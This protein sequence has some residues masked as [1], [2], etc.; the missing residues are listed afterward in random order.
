MYMDK[1]II[2]FLKKVCERFR[3]RAI[4]IPDV[5]NK[6]DLWSIT[7][8]Q[9]YGIMTFTTEIF[10]HM[11]S[12]EREKMIEPTIKR[13]LSTLLGE[14]NVQKNNTLLNHRRMGKQ[15]YP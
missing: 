14:R 2:V 4:F 12:R 9:G 6:N 5:D 15:I 11:A 3:L 13:G 8:P 7:T 10:Y 1:N